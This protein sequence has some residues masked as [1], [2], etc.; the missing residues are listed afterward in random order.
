MLSA[1]D[2]RNDSQVILYDQFLPG[3]TLLA[4]LDADHW[5]VGVPM[6]RTHD[7]IGA[8][9]VDQNAYPRDAVYQ[10]L[11]RFIEEDLGQAARALRYTFIRQASVTARIAKA[12]STTAMRTR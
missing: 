6:A 12:P 3:S 11:L 8:L 4:Y 2:S 9:L 1:L 7:V 10:A 5:A